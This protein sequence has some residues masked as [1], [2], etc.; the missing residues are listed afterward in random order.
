[1]PAVRRLCVFC[2]S[3]PGLRPQHADAARAVGEAIA[4]R[5]WGLVYGGG[6]VGLS[7]RASDT[8]RAVGEAS[9]SRGGGLV[10]GGGRVGLM[11]I[12]ADAALRGGA[13]VDGV[14]P[15]HLAVKEVGHTGL[16]RLHLVESMH[17][18]KAMMASLADGF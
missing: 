5:G 8:G 3:N 15:R 12:L 10:Y 4:S 14:L 16:T 1:M 13:E 11:G 7:G 9:A 18:R 6:R 17:E 2:G